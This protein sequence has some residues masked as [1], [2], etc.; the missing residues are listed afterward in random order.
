MGSVQGSG[1]CTPGH[2]FGPSG[3]EVGRGV[4]EAHVVAGFSPRIFAADFRV[5]YRKRECKI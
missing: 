4:P 3:C 2:G 1:L 5:A